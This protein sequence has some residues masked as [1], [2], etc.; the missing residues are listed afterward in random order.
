MIRRD[1]TFVLIVPIL[2]VTWVAQRHER[3]G[4]RLESTEGAL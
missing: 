2:G 3:G 4:K 1:L